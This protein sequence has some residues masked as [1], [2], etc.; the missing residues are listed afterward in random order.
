MSKPPARQ[1]PPSPKARAVAE[2]QAAP[3]DAAKA[4]RAGLACERAQDFRA[5]LRW[6]DRAAA[7][8]PADPDILRRFGNL[9]LY[10][11]DLQQGLMLL[12]MANA[13]RPADDL[14]LKMAL[15]IPQVPDGLDSL[16]TIR[17]RLALALQA[18]ERTPLTIVDPVE[19]VTSLFSFAYYSADN[20]AE[21]RRY[22]EAL[23][24]IYRRACPSLV[25]EAPHCRSW[26]KRA[27]GERI[28]VG[29][30]SRFLF[31]HSIGR[32][33]ERLISG[34]DRDRFEVTLG[35]IGD[36]SDGLTER[37]IASADRVLRL[38]ADLSQARLALAAVGLDVIVYPEIG[39]DAVVLLLAHARLAPVQA[40]TWGHPCTTGIPT[41]DYFISSETLEAEG[42][43]A[44][45][46]ETLIRLPCLTVS[47]R[48]QVPPP[49]SGRARF[50]LA[51][52]RTVYIVAQYVFK[53][54]P[55]F[56]A[57]LAEVLR[58]DPDG[59]VLMVQGVPRDRLRQTMERRLRRTL[60]PEAAKRVRFLPVMRREA[61]LSLLGQCDVSLDV[62]QFNGGNTTFEALAMG[63]PV[64]TLPTSEM[65]GR[66]AAAILRQGG[67][68]DLVA[69][70][71]E[72]YVDLA[73]TLGTDADL[74][75]KTR[76]R[77]FAAHDRLFDRDEP[78]HAWEDWLESV[79]GEGE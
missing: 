37:L 13:F 47:Y 36:R 1:R 46:S 51:D 77:I 63:V 79:A 66:L 27:K 54:H 30:V 31:D 28:R 33:N 35:L 44:H 16:R 69:A 50:G 14:R 67:L 68:Y 40:T 41:V 24:R 23:A 15:A 9:M 2:A 42:G 3:A 49:P 78:I 48:R 61:F 25:V 65:R 20:G 12:G 32:L 70:S 8:A 11:D 58:R 43:E 17:R 72:A 19:N 21:D 57:I 52:G 75:A 6:Y 60:G 45:Y 18:M 4:L 53:V 5:A 74:R 73:V 10:L 62:P 34:L 59:V 76:R 22:Y 39:M 64:V 56:D 26:R 71:P 38:P 29:F 55:A 7:L